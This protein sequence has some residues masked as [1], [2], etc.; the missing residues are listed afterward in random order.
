M[1]QNV[2]L[3][4]VISSS[5]MLAINALVSG[6]SVTRAAEAAGVARETVSR[7]VHRD[8]VFIAELQNTRAELAAQ[9][10]LGLEALGLWAVG[11]LRDA[12]QNSFM[13]P[14]RL[15]KEVA[16]RFHEPDAAADQ[17]GA[18]DRSVN[19]GKNDKT[20]TELLRD[21]M[22]RVPR[23]APPIPADDRPCNRVAGA[24]A[25]GGGGSVP[26]SQ[27]P[28]PDLRLRH[29]IPCFSPCLGPLLP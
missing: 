9:T 5:Q 3:S 15:R 28:S 12:L 1:S 25:T 14:T 18:T 19:G 6:S 7:W 29:P 24:T 21:M 10:R 17:A 11:T 27:A 4:A 8:P 22:N 20:L 2:T 23:P 16:A 26:R 13:L